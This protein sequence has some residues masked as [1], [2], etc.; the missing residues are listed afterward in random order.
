M[1]LYF[2]G[3]DWDQIDDRWICIRHK[4]HNCYNI[5]YVKWKRGTNENEV[6]TIDNKIIIFED[7]FKNS[8]YGETAEEFIEDLL[9]KGVWIEISEN[10]A[11]SYESCQ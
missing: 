9:K 7:I 10:K 2:K 8:Y 11:L 6:I 4:N 5:A 1:S 3:I